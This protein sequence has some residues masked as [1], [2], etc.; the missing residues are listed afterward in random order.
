MPAERFYL[1]ADYIKGASLCLT[2]T[3]H[4][5]LSHV[6]R[7]R[8]GEQVELVNGRGGLATAQITDTEK[9]RT[10]LEILD[11]RTTPPSSALL[12]A[13]VPLMR[14]AKL[15]WVIEKGTELGTDAFLLYRADHSE[16][17]TLSTHQIDRLRHLTISALKQSGRLH[18]PPLEILPHLTALFE[19][20]GQCLFGDIR[21]NAPPL[22]RG[23]TITTLFITGPEQGFSKDEL[24]LLDQ[25]A[26]GVRINP[27]ILRA[28][29]APIAA[30]SIIKS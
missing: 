1:N 20:E 9:Q 7:L 26:T 12:I 17:E 2:G 8:P 15:E 27:N 4:H 30:I 24:S 11:E 3:E 21:P 25:K 13:A 23:C 10:T 14:P 19:R 29:T 6:M 18:L 5:H 16:K 22:P 28:E